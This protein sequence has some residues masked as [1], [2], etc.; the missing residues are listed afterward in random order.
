MLTTVALFAA[1]TSALGHADGLTLSNVR[2]TYY[3]LGPTRTDDK[4]VAGDSYHIAFD[5]EGLKAAP[6]GKVEYAMGLKVLNSAGKVEF[7]SDPTPKEVYNAL[8]GSTVPAY[9]NVDIGLNQAPGKYTLQVTVIDTKTKAKQEL[10]RDF[11]VVPKKF[12]LVRLSTTADGNSVPCG[13]FGIP[14]QSLYV[15]FFV[16]D[17]AK[18]AKQ[19]PNITI[20]MKIVDENGKQTLEEPADETVKAGNVANVVAIP[21]TFTIHLNRP[22]KFTAEFT[23]TDKAANKEAKISLPITVFDVKASR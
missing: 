16:I 9:A 20:K 17:F 1:L 23:A 6:N 13:P 10:S 2:Q 19:Q 21:I 14:G 5:I 11:E 12:A 7:G 4:V 3:L 22:G 18:D 8:G 15:H